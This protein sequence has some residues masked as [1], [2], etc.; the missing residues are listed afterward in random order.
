MAS[1]AD[2]EFVRNCLVK[3]FAVESTTTWEGE[4]PPDIYIKVKGETIAVEITRLS[5]VSFDQKFSAQ[6]R[7][8]QAYFGINLCNE[9]DL[10]LKNNVPS[11]VDIILTLY[12]P[13]KNGRKYKSELYGRLKNFIAQNLKAGTREKIKIVDDEVKISVVPNREHSQKKI[14]GIVVN[15]NSSPD[16]L[17]NAEVILLGRI[18]DKQEKCRKI[19]HNGPIWL[20]L[21]NDYWLADHRTY[22]QALKNISVSHDFEKIFVVSDIGVVH[23]IYAKT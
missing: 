9:L 8:T 7:N 13:V 21:F 3:Y 10:K 22:A 23:Q 14:V 1:R 18:K 20:A 12:V 16:I 4:D 15:K 19:K 6:N 11:E 5:P 17:G 2:E